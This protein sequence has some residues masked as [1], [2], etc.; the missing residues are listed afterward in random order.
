[1]TD[2]STHR[3]RF[4]NNPLHRC[5]RAPCRSAPSSGGVV[6]SSNNIKSRHERANRLIGAHT[7]LINANRCTRVRACRCRAPRPA[8][9]R[10]RVFPEL[11]QC[12]PS[13]P[14]SP[15]PP[16]L[17]P[18]PW[19]RKHRAAFPTSLKRA[20]QPE[21]VAGSPAPRR[22]QLTVAWRLVRE[23]PEA[24]RARSAATVQVLGFRGAVPLSRWR[25]G[26]QETRR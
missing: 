11:H 23:T 6:G 20:V 14:P 2:P 8:L 1:M 16:P 17:A 3:R 21:T 22:R 12:R 18:P 4:V 26:A 15:L 9:R 24:S 13:P 10:L 25:R 7:T 19:P 5:R